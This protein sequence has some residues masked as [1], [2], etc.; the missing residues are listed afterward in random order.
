MCRK[1]IRA[2]VSRHATGNLPEAL[3]RIS[4]RTSVL[5]F[6]HDQLF[7]VADCEAD[8]RLIRGGELHVIE[9]AWGHWG[10]E[11]TAAARG[12]LDEHLRVL[13]AR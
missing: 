3:G 8:A 7:P 10:F 13:L 2:D 6:S 9:S 11:M 12:A 1:W 5:A 4:A